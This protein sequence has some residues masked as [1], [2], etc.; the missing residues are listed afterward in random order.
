MGALRDRMEADL[1]LLGRAEN[2]QRCYLRCAGQF[3]RAKMGEQ[4]ELHCGFRTI[5]R[6]IATR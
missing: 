5:A 4:T 2:T 6:P 3:A 1:K